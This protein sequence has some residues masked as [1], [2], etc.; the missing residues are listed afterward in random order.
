VTDPTTDQTITDDPTDLGYFDGDPVLGMGIEIRNAGGGLNEAL[1]VD[2]VRHSHRE[3]VYVVLE[4]EMT[5][6]THKWDADDESWKRIEVFR[7]VNQ[8]F[9]TRDLVQAA[10]NNYAEHLA[11]VRARNENE[12]ILTGRLQEMRAAHF[13]GEH[14]ELLDGCP[15][16][17]EEVRLDLEEI[18]E[19]TAAAILA[20]IEGADVDIADRIEA[21]AA[22]AI[23]DPSAREDGWDDPLPARRGVLGYPP[24][25]NEGPGEDY[26]GGVL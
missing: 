6:L 7:A 18:P 23:A 12:M 1:K 2:P 21:E 14:K 26:A 11:D 3:K 20:D 8:A 17:D 9:V 10:L 16:C 4:C 5:Q 22:A 24:G 25:F 19:A 13:L 15:D